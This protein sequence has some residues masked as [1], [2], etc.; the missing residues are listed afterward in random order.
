MDPPAES[1]WE[2]PGLLAT[3][4]GNGACHFPPLQTQ[5]LPLLPDF[6]PDV[7][8][9][10]G[11]DPATFQRSPPILETRCLFRGFGVGYTSCQIQGL[12]YLES[13]T[14]EAQVP[15]GLT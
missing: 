4:Q 1:A 9:L 3:P 10:E 11:L 7:L 15:L 8:A 12:G 5:P 2:V 6:S 14:L 13:C